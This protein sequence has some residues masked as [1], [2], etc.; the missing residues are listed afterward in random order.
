MNITEAHHVNTL[1][2]YLAKDDRPGGQVIT[3]ADAEEA[4]RFLAGKAYK[5]LMA[6]VT[7]EQVKV[8]R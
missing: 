5:A 1:L 2:G 7:P 3:A 4:A 8:L 6:G